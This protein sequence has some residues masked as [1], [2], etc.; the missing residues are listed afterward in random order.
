MADIEVAEPLQVNGASDHP[1]P[2]SQLGQ[3]LDPE[4]LINYLS[5]LLS[6]TLGASQDDLEGSGSLLSAE[7][8]PHTVKLCTRFLSEAQV[9]LYAQKNAV[10]S[11]NRDGS[12][13]D[14]G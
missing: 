5:L 12:P 2:S 8:V 7:E 6:V 13:G 3:S 4:I 1:L 9:A 10:S 14:P 11:I